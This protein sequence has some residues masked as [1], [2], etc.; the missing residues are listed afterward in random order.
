MGQREPHKA[1]NLQLGRICVWGH[2]SQDPHPGGARVNVSA[3]TR[4][5]D[6]QE[7]TGSQ[8]PVPAD[9]PSSSAAG[10][11]H[12]VRGAAHRAACTPRG[13]ATST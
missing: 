8:R 1:S 13:L 5:V 12:A 4:P 6:P 11:P 10:R 9:Q 2:A 7:P 3:A